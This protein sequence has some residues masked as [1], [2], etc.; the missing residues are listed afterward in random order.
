M[1]VAEQ[2]GE[3][4]I[5]EETTATSQ[6]WQLPDGRR[7]T[8]ISSVPVR[9]Q[10]EQGE[11]QPIDND[12]VDSPASGV[13]VENAA[14]D[15]QVELPSDASQRAVRL[16]HDDAWVSFRMEGL[17]GAPAVAGSSATY[18]DADGVGGSLGADEVEYEATNTGVKESIVLAEVPESAPVYGFRLRASAGLQPELT[19]AG[20]VH[21]TDDSG[22][23]IFVMPAPFMTDSAAEPVTSTDVG[24]GL[25]DVADGT[26]RLT[27]R[28]SLAWLSAAERVYPVIIDPTTT[29]KPADDIKDCWIT[30]EIK[31]QANCEAS[32]DLIR[33]GKLDGNERRGLVQFNTTSVVPVDAEVSSATLKMYMTGG[34]S[35]KSMQLVARRL[36]NVPN[37]SSGGFSSTNTTWNNRYPGKPWATPGG[38]F[39]SG[40][41][42]NPGLT[43]Q[44]IPGYRSFTATAAVQAWFQGEQPVLGLLVRTPDSSP[45]NILYFCSADETNCDG[46]GVQ[47]PTLTITY[48]TPPTLAASGVSITPA[49]TSAALTVDSLT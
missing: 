13:A 29:T 46:K 49:R 15:V 43:G 30:E 22:E 38:D 19:A 17:D 7:E 2:M 42:S 25:S 18:G 37:V 31:T 24:Y 9:F 44:G 34:S 20:E 28:P 11:W 16:V 12:L 1:G 48:D 4:L 41:D 27:V 47:P 6:T 39:A 26:W 40:S 14:N 5:P 33:V 8:E 45:A 23:R 36:T 3:S 10:D 21:F 32:S 35:N